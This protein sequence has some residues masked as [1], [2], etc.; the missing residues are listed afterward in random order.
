MEAWIVGQRIT[1]AVD[2]TTLDGW[3]IGELQIEMET[4]LKRMTPCAQLF[5]HGSPGDLWNVST[6]V[7]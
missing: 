7:Q 6:N 1:S 4:G 5:V 3:S 2:V